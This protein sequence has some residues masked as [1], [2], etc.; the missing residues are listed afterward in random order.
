MKQENFYAYCCIIIP[1]EA[2]VFTGYW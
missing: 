2:S 1:S